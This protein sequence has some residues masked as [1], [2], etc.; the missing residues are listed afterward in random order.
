MDTP[1]GVDT[2]WIDYLTIKT[3]GKIVSNFCGNR[4]LKF[5]WLDFINKEPT[6]WGFINSKFIPEDD[7][8]LKPQNLGPWLMK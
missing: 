4:K 3:K 8:A 6:F 5:D 2:R 7:Q 1:F